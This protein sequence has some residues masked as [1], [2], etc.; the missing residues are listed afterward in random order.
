VREDTW[1]LLAVGPGR[2]GHRSC[3]RAA[4]AAGT[5]AAELRA[6]AADAG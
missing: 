5:G 3:G 6:L 2:D 1:G 4:V